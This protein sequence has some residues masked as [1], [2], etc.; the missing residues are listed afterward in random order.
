MINLYFTNY[1]ENK[2]ETARQLQI[3][4]SMISRWIE[5][6]DLLEAYKG[7]KEKRKIS[8]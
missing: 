7:M 6:K 3:D 4:R 2:S 1:N 5:N 8:N